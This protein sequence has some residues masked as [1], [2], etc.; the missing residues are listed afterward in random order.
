MSN[1]KPSAEPVQWQPT[2]PIGQSI[3]ED[4]A[5]KKAPLGTRLEVGDRTFYYAQASAAVTAGTIMCMGAPG[6]NISQTAGAAAAVGTKEV[7]FYA[8][9]GAVTKDEYA[10]GYMWSC[11]GD[12]PGQMYR[13]KA[14]DAI[15]TSGTG[16]VVLYDEIYDALAITDE[17]SLAHNQYK[18]TYVSATGHDA[19][20]AGVAP[21][22]VTGEYYY[23]CQ[24]F[25]P[26]A[27]YMDEIIT[28]NAYA[29]A[30]ATGAANM[31][32][33]ATTAGAIVQTIIGKARQTG[34]DTEHNL[35]QLTLRPQY[36]KQVSGELTLPHYPIFK[37]MR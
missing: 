28:D 8:G 13:V 10:E 15:V 33:E 35:I 18:D 19:V 9:A 34:V 23:W 37:E 25:G 24:T 21:C 26:A 17:I 29:A 6:I 22:A 11:D 4:S 31:A 2:I 7:T 32:I 3:N 5:T 1:M 36:H 30:G 20:V 14:N 27:V 16:T 12:S